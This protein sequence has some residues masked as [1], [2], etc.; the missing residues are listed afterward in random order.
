M[1]KRSKALAY[2][3]FVV[4][5]GALFYCYEY[6]LRVSPS[7]MANKLMF[8]YH[9]DGASL[10]NLHAYYYYIYVPM[11]LF[12]GILFD[13]YGPRRLLIMA[14]GCCA[15]GIYIFAASHFLILAEI[16]RLLMGFGSAFAFVG[17]LK[18]ATIWLPPERFAF[19]SGLAVMLG[20]LGGMLGDVSL[21]A[22]VHSVG[23]MR[24]CDYAAV[25]G[26]ILLILVVFFIRDRNPHAVRDMQDVQLHSV[27]LAWPEI[28][29][30][31]TDSQFWIN[32]F[33]GCLLYLPLSAFAEIWA[34]PFLHEAYGMSA[35]H[36]ADAS[37]L[38][39]LGMACGGPAMGFLSDF[40]RQRRIL[41]TIGSMCGAV[42]ICAL[43]YMPD[44]HPGTIYLLCF[45]F[46]FTS[47]AQV[48]AFAVAREISPRSLTGTTL[49][50]TNMIVMIGGFL[51][52]L[53]GV[54]LDSA[55]K[56]KIAADG[57]HL[58]SLGNFQFALAILPVALILC[59]LLSFFLAE[60]HG[61]RKY[62]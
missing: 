18:L 11:Q 53:I 10:G 47:G 34:I 24:T 26:V 46:G 52:P 43:L 32:G 33:I 25:V 7:V 31:V 45:I 12:V 8:F 44:L 28:K 62:S 15:V 60:T 20:M 14:V 50:S 48:L 54:L 40:I 38:V 17:V 6:L 9:L 41:V 37:S 35:S 22:L 21:T 39:F 2:G 19:I 49:A 23:W 59:A 27:K 29:R 57:V 5:L 1:K 42:V 30:V 55:W 3:W 58:Y 16:G 61:Q 51:V 36:A 4:F 56:G 13:R